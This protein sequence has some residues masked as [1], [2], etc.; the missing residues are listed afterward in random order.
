M[1]PRRQAAD[2]EKKKKDFDDFK[3]SE[4]YKSLLYIFNKR[5]GLDEHGN[6]ELKEF[7]NGTDDIL[8]DWE[9]ILTR[10]FKLVEAFKV[11]GRKAKGKQPQT[12]THSLTSCAALL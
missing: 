10:I 2:P 6:H 5:K 7:A 9:G 12:E 1:P 8:D 4:E 11:P 3:E